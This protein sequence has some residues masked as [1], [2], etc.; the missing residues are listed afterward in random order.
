DVKILRKICWKK[1]KEN[2]VNVFLR[3]KAN[4]NVFKNYDYVVICTYGSNN[5]L[6][7]KEDKVNYQYELCEKPVVYLPEEF[8]R[9]SIV[10]LDGPFMCVD[11]LG[12]SKRFLLGNVK[13][14]I[15]STNIGKRPILKSKYAHLL[16]NGII[17]DPPITNFGLFIESGSRFI[18][19]L[20]KAKHVGSM[21]TFRTVLPNR[22]STDERPTIVKKH[23]HK[24]ISVF[25]GKIPSC[26]NAAHEVDKIINS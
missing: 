17:K 22:E 15:H 16:N 2:N 1:L 12:Y 24:V 6:L 23:N 18:P 10:I 9:K 4:K 26:I 21:F 7:N 14:A 5:L 3:Q 13:H 19:K 20:K 25:S 8:S 11:P